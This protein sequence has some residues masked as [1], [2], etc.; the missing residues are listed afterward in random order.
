M[1]GMPKQ[2]LYN[3]IVADQLAWMN[4]SGMGTPVPKPYGTTH[5]DVDKKFEQNLRELDEWISEKHKIQKEI[6]DEQ[7]N[8]K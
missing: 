1:R 7:Q 5:A 3:K 6:E 8:I 4:R 2:N